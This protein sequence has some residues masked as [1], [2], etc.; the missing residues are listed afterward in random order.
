M[1]KILIS[2]ICLLSLTG[3][4]KIVEGNYKEGTYKVDVQV[5]GT[6]AKAQYTSKIKQV[7]VKISKK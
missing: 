4:E 2:L 5:E 7:E 3:C 1:K 6:D